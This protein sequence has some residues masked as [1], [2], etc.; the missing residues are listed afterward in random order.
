MTKLFDP[1]Y[2]LAALL[3]AKAKKEK[4]S[5][6]VTTIE[7]IND[8]INYLQ[9]SANKWDKDVVFMIDKARLNRMINDF[10]SYFSVANYA[11]AISEDS[12]VD[13]LEYFMAII[14]N[15]LKEFI[16][17]AAFEFMEHKKV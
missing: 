10:K 9:K 16:M 5:C 7:E 2:I 4:T 12:S 1:E 15:E 8:F 11:F 13:G 14:P 17:V 3:I 6:P